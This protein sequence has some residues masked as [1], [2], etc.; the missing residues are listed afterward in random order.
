MRLLRP[1]KQ[2]QNQCLLSFIGPRSDYSRRGVSSWLSC[3]CS[4]NSA[5]LNVS[6]ECVLPFFS[7]WDQS[8]IPGSIHFPSIEVQ[9]LLFRSGDC[10]QP[11][12]H[13]S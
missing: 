9:S 6:G 1:P 13:L 11:H 4:L 7:I 10:S 12:F 8:G 2:R 3:C 5:A